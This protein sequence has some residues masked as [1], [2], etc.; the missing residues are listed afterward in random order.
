MITYFQAVEFV[1]GPY[2]GHKEIVTCEPEELAGMLAL[3]VNQNV[4]RLMRGDQAGRN[5]PATSL[6]VYHRTSDDGGCRYFFLG[7]TTVNHA[8][9]APAGA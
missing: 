6:A 4:F 5:L 8:V 2:D 1:G 9:Q 3:P 7:S